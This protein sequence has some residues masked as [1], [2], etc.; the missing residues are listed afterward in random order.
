MKKYPYNTKEGTA[1]SGDISLSYQLVAD[2]VPAFYVKFRSDDLS[3]FTHGFLR[4][5]ARDAFNEEGAKYTLEEVYGAKKEELLNNIK[6]RIN[7]EVN[8]YGVQL[9]QFGFT[10]RL[11]MDPKI[12]AALNNKLTTTQ[13]AI[14]A[15]NRLR[16]AQANAANRVATAE[17][18]AK[19]N[20]VLAQSITPQLIQW[21][22]L[23]INEK[24]IGYWKGGVPYVMG[25]NTNGLLLQLPMMAPTK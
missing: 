8:Q 21:R 1:V 20:L 3:L 13:N 7:K 11:R 23:D 15:E 18:E 19:A 2:K 22:T 9:V 25:G 24:A 14:A 5:I 6:T 4:N 10:G 17:G 16:E 12:M